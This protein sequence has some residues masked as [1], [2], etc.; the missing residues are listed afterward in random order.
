MSDITVREYSEGDL[1]RMRELTYI[2]FEDV[3]ISHRIEKKYGLIGG[4]DWKFRKGGEFDEIM[5]DERA[6]AFV[7]EEDGNVIGYISTI[8]NSRESRIGR[9]VDFAVEPGHQ[10]KGVGRS[11]FYAAQEYFRAEGMEYIKIETLANNAAGTHFYP[12]LGFETVAVQNH[13]IMPLTSG[14]KEQQ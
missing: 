8:I 3:S 11:L 1:P 7:A 2:C 13:Y 12:K 14:E 5:N 4:R 9:I 10:K 6:N